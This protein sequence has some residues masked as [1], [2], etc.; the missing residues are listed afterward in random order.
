MFNT[1]FGRHCFKKMPSRLHSASEVSQGTFLKTICRTENAKKSQD[2][3]ITWRKDLYCHNKALKEVFEKIRNHGLKLNKSKCQIA[4]N[5]LVFLEH[6]ISSDG[7]KED[8]KKVYGI[9]M[10]SPTNKTE[11]QKFF[12][13]LNCFRKFISNSPIELA[14][15]RELLEKDNEFIFDNP[16]I[17]AFN[18]TVHHT[19]HH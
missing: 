17:D 7:F 19:M 12:G 5:E 13:M 8:P 6:I 4:V 2:D 10:A 11:L 9:I 14:N 3:I 15:L 1:L 18:S 16:Q